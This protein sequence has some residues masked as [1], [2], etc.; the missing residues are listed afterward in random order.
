M[1]W[2]SR[3]MTLPQG[4]ERWVVVYTPASVERVRQ[5]MQRQVSK[6]QTRWEQTCWHFSHRG[7][8][9]EADACAALE[10]ELKGKP[11]WFEVESS[12]IAHAQY[13]AKGRPPKDASPSGYQWQLVVSVSVNS[14]QVVQEV[15]RKACWI[16]GT[17]VPLANDPL[18]SATDCH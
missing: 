12:V 5:T 16:V 2:F 18:Q 10:R 4:R 17:N 13:G 3:E 6:V 8:A 15:F 11:S 1:S 9:C 14:F 7:F